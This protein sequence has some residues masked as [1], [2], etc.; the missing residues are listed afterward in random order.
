MTRTI[1]NQQV[2]IVSLKSGKFL[3]ILL[4]RRGSRFVAKSIDEIYQ[5]L[6]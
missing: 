2:K 1:N 3:A 6:A 5:R 4:G